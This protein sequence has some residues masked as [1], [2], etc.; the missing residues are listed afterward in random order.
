M[1]EKDAPQMEPHGMTHSQIR[2]GA[3]AE[4]EVAVAVEEVTDS[5]GS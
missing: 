5:V 1:R 4:L 2:R 3:A